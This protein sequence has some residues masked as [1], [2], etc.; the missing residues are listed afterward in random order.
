MHEWKL[1]FKSERLRLDALLFSK[2]L[3]VYNK[4]TIAFVLGGHV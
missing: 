1:C 4:S 2:Y 3:V